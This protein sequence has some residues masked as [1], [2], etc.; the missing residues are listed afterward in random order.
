MKYLQNLGPQ[1][2]V[3]FFVEENVISRIDLHLSKN[4]GISWEIK[5]SDQLES[6][7]FRWMEQYCSGISSNIFIPLKKVS[8]PIFHSKGIITFSIYPIWT[9]F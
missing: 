7:I 3:I 6:L 2:H 5:G 4:T 9:K 1:I 8:F